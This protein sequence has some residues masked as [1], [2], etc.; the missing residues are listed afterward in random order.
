MQLGDLAVGVP[1]HGHVVLPPRRRQRRRPPELLIAVAELASP[2]TSGGNTVIVPS[3]FHRVGLPSVLPTMTPAL[4]MAVADPELASGDRTGCGH[5]RRRH[6]DRQGQSHS[7]RPPRADCVCSLLIPLGPCWK[8]VAACRLMRQ[9][10]A[11]LRK[12]EHELPRELPAGLPVKLLGGTDGLTYRV[13]FGTNP[14][15]SYCRLGVFREP[16]DGT[17]WTCCT[18]I[19]SASPV[20]T[21]VATPR[22]ASPVSFRDRS[23]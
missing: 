4:L 14:K 18:A 22:S 6:S 12:R 16:G 7:R 3:A 17:T 9:K 13:N 10:S 23:C 21:S 11:W 15:L 20:A 19:R 2:A 1:A 8:R 5:R